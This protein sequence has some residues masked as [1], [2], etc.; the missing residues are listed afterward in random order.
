MA[1][2]AFNLTAQINLRG[3]SNV[4][5]IVSDIRKQVS[6]ISV[7]ITPKI[8]NA[9]IK[10]V[11]DLN[12]SFR[13][14]NSTLAI[15]T[16]NTRVTAKALSDL[17]KSVNAIG[18]K[19]LQ[20]NL[21][22]ATKA[23]AD[24]SK[25][26]KDVADSAKSASSGMEEFG[27]QSALAIRRFAAFSIVSSAVFG[28]IGA[29]REGTKAF[30]DFDKEFIRLQQVS[31]A[32]VGSLKILSN[33]I[34]ELS[35]NLGVSSKD[36]TTV[37][38]TLAQAG[39]SIRD[40]EQALKAL[41]KSALAPSFDN[42]NDTVEGS[43][44]LM[45][46]F[47]IASNELEAAL[48]SVN[49][50]SK[51]FA[52]ESSDL[53]AAIQRTGG[54]FAAASKGVSEG[55]DALNEFLAL[56][57]SVR[58][59]TRESAE[60]IATGLR[61]IFTRIQRGSTI[62]AL[63]EFGIQ[64]T[65]LEGKFVGPFEAIRRLS[66][67][68]SSLDP[69]DLRFSQIIEELGG[70]RQIGKVIPLIQ[71]FAVA[72][73]ALKVAQQGTDSLAQDAATAQLSLAIQISK[74]REEFTALIRSIGQS[75]GFRSLVSLALDL[76]SGLIK[77]ADAAKGVLPALVALG[78]IRGLSALTKFGAGFAS[79][80]R[81]S[82]IKLAGGG[83]VY[84]FNKGGVVPGSGKGD[85]VPAMLEPGEV[86][87]SNVAVQK[88]GRGNLVRM[89]RD[90][91]SRFA[92]G[93]QA[94]TFGVASLYPFDKEVADK[95]GSF[96]V[97]DIRG[98]L[99]RGSNI[100]AQIERVGEGEANKAINKVLGFAPIENSL[101][102][103]T[104]VIA[105]SVNNAEAAKILQEDVKNSI[106]QLID[107]SANVLA[108]ALGFDKKQTVT[109]NLIN[110]VGTASTLGSVFEGALALLGAPQ[111]DNKKEQDPFD[112]PFGL[113]QLSGSA[114]NTTFSKIANMPVDAK[115][116]A[117][118]ER[119]TKVANIKAKNYL[120]DEVKKSNEWQEFLTK[121]SLSGVEKAALSKFNF[122][123][124]NPKEDY[125]LTTLGQ[126]T[127]VKGANIADF[128]G[129][130]KPLQLVKGQIGGRGARYKLN[131]E[132]RASGGRSDNAINAILTPGEA[133]IG[134]DTAKSIGYAKL[135]RM[136]YA[137]KNGMQGFSGGDVSIVPGVGNTDSF[138]PV[139]LPVGSYVIRKKATEA[140]GFN[141]GGSVG[142]R[143]F[144]N[145]G[146]AQPQSDV[147][148]L[149][150]VL[151]ATGLLATG[152]L[153]ITKNFSSVSASLKG[154]LPAL[155]DFRK[156]L[157]NKNKAIAQTTD[158]TKK[159]GLGM[160]G[161]IAS[162]GGATVIEGIGRSIGGDT[163]TRVSGI[164]T[165][166]LNFGIL[167]AQI[168]S[169]IP[170][171][172]TALGLLV[173][174]GLGAVQGLKD[175]TKAIEQEARARQEAE[176]QTVR[177]N[178]AKRQEEEEKRRAEAAK[179][180]QEALARL[181][182]V[183]IQLSE[184]YERANAITDRFG[185]SLE[186]ISRINTSRISDFGDRT[187]LGSVSRLDESVLK[188]ITA[189]SVREV[190]AT[191]NRLSALAG[192]GQEGRDLAQ[193]VVAQKLIR[194]Q[195]PGLLREV[196]QRGIGPAILQLSTSLQSQLGVDKLSGPTAK[197]IKELEKAIEKLPEGTPIAEAAEEVEKLFGPIAEAADKL[198]LNIFTQY[199]NALE[200]ATDLWNKW[201]EA[202]EQALDFTRRA[203]DIRLKSEIDLQ[204]T[205][206]N[207]LS[208][209]ALNKPFEQGIRS[210]TGGITD[211]SLIAQKLDQ[212][213]NTNIAIE[214]RIEQLRA[215]TNEQNVQQTNLAIEA[216]QQALAKNKL[217]INQGTKALQELASNGD[218][219]A[220]ALSKIQELQQRAG[221]F[222]GLVRGLATSDPQERA[223]FVQ[224]TGA[225]RL[226]RAALQRGVGPQAFR[227]EKFVNDF[228]AGFER[229]RSLLDPGVA[230]EI[231]KE[232]T[233]SLLQAQGINVDAFLPEFGRTIREIV[234]LEAG[235]IDEEDPLL[236]SF[237]EAIEA[238]A[239]ANEELSKRSETQGNL[240]L[241]GIKSVFDNLNTEFPKIVKRA[242]DAVQAD[243]AAIMAARAGVRS[244]GGIIYANKG[245][246]ISQGFKPRGKDTVPAMTTNGQPYMLQPGEFVVN[247]DATD[248]NYGLLK[249]INNGDN[250]PSY[251][252]NRGGSI[253]EQ[254]ADSRRQKFEAEQERRRQLFAQ[255]FP[256]KAEAAEKRRLGR[257]PD[258]GLG[259]EGARDLARTQADIQRSNVEDK[260]NQIFGDFLSSISDDYYRNLDDDT[261]YK[262]LIERNLRPVGYNLLETNDR[263]LADSA[264]ETFISSYENRASEP[265]R[266][267]Q[268]DAK[269]AKAAAEKRAREAEETAVSVQAEKEASDTR[270]AAIFAPGN[271][272]IDRTQAELDRKRKELEA[273]IEAD[274]IA[275]TQINPRTGKPFENAAQQQAVKVGDDDRAKRRG[276]E[277]RQ[278]RIFAKRKN[279]DRDSEL[280]VSYREGLLGSF[281][282]DEEFKE[283]NFDRGLSAFVQQ[284]L[285][286]AYNNKALPDES[287]LVPF[288]PNKQEILRIAQKARLDYF[289]EGRR[290]SEQKALIAAQKDAK[291]E[292]MITVPGEAV[293]EFGLNLAG[294]VGSSIGNF[295]TAAGGVV[296]IGGSLI[297][298]AGAA[299]LEGAGALLAD[300]P[301]QSGSTLQTTLSN[302]GAS[303]R[304]TGGE[305]LDIGLGDIQLGA[306][307][308]I[309]AFGSSSEI[310]SQSGML[311]PKEEQQRLLDIREEKIKGLVRTATGNQ[312]RTPRAVKFSENPDKDTPF[313]YPIDLRD[314]GPSILDAIT[315]PENIV[316]GSMLVSD[317][318]TSEAVFGGGAGKGAE[319]VTA[320]RQAVVQS[321]KRAAEQFA[322]R[323]RQ[324]T[325]QLTEQARLDRIIESSEDIISKSGYN[326]RQIEIARESRRGDR[327]AL[328]LLEES[329]ETVSSVKPKISAQPTIKP[330]PIEPLSQLS[331]AEKI[332]E[333]STS[334]RAVLEKVSEAP[335]FTR[336][337]LE[338]EAL[339]RQMSGQTGPA[340]FKTGGMSLKDMGLEV[341][342]FSLAGPTPLSQL[343]S[344]EQIEAQASA[345]AQRW[346]DAERMTKGFNTGGMVRGKPGIDTNL[347]ALT[348]G[349]FVVNAQDTPKNLEALRYMNNGGVI[350]PRYMQEGGGPLGS[351]STSSPSSSNTNN[352]NGYSISL[353][354]KSRTFMETFVKD[355]NTFGKDFNT[356]I[357]E[358]S[359]IRIPDKI[360]MVGRHTVEVNVT[361]AAAFEAIEQ[362]VLNLIN[363]EIGKEMNTLWEQ[364]GGQLGRSN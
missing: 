236:K 259:R 148:S 145:G 126:L 215:G 270:I 300:L 311:S 238:Q 161:L 360:E 97:E 23:S 160:T 194:Q 336:E 291:T 191:A 66:D 99:S 329:G 188:N 9:V 18:S 122:D 85:K 312:Q 82:N 32:S 351:S 186:E 121:Q 116:T 21:N 7:D 346:F 10:N 217:A 1:N 38:V 84:G 262:D 196:E 219:A 178:Q 325:Q 340:R 252:A 173:G 222:G 31:G 354:D 44:A 45:R 157:F 313:P 37:S 322:R 142:V 40:T 235:K 6:S 111:P 281:R 127:K 153:L 104:R 81:P 47:G 305:M 113:G 26:T 268:E 279:W 57:T 282:N 112:F 218:K 141:S 225:F 16:A 210:L 331:S 162:L 296:R 107:N 105:D 61:T 286:E 320:T 306:S 260:K 147:F 314:I 307:R 28:L 332:A 344:A 261:K 129:P 293:K 93:G 115:V 287:S 128:V 94:R 143:K 64:L 168:G 17:A 71:Q 30:I 136:N 211:P 258:R 362:G 189:F 60:T 76:T 13:D 62:N 24:L 164:G 200:Q 78:T 185:S 74:V 120:A 55:S 156:N 328:R 43:I 226:G 294:G 39:L 152:L 355:L 246:L 243:A 163:G 106:G 233:I 154:V 326:L 207:N 237:R 35:V 343:S 240:I 176:V 304:Q 297:A 131:V 323:Q 244:N 95:E 166:A 86:V 114:K 285:A 103:S 276:E 36:L 56:F 223:S 255:R 25:K 330:E 224:Q 68:L 119:L 89:N 146:A 123:K 229:F 298:G 150:N 350:K 239:E 230:A 352:F 269:I 87:M 284:K 5:K 88:Y 132:N 257:R 11:K 206:G 182:Q 247:K 83:R 48:G 299:T 273:S 158:N 117:D 187:Q 232:A 335:V 109:D 213:A 77:L 159:L 52:V 46:Q 51:S 70:F 275:R 4:K 190:S 42:L 3:P 334:T 179:K 272:D 302:L 22:N 357:S 266:Q 174:A 347:A 249:A 356:Y 348:S 124:L 278:Q 214:R 197:I 54:V 283:F 149:S 91:S 254:R 102:I 125:D 251:Y 341:P 144:A 75:E 364:S 130:G 170:G 339:R 15:T 280:A 361:G 184:V 67:G 333:T 29:L 245:S 234:E 80:I 8:N 227:N 34:S 228:F 79:T 209:E 50:V 151:T 33:T 193:T 358:L 316:R 253:L 201:I 195:L 212:L 181:A 165:S 303:I 199:N 180:A 69:R 177:E 155:N 204:R 183:S 133:V 248:K 63:E 59:T 110:S 41:A 310:F 205:L 231:Q 20:Q 118:S 318:L 198:S 345:L 241:N 72:Q 250:F 108:G 203:A 27:K 208:L 101:P 175:S 290:I 49:A 342:D 265:A 301:A 327:T 289:K 14:F 53:I 363:T 242:F 90:M 267:A 274:R 192:G 135:N 353:E 263:A 264:I 308:Q 309:E 337:M 167:G 321:N 139:P 277:Q 138:G 92:F 134:P 292:R 98:V 19:K 220:N 256:A 271:A 2:G 171:V 12:R 221:A 140:L 100:Q 73:Q 58:Q 319:A 137:D 65:D 96:S 315:D 349:E 359:K 324:I 202:T 288:I 317:V 338:Q 216:Q 172:G 295:L 169:V